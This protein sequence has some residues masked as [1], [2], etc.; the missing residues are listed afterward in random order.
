[1]WEAM[2]TASTKT[3]DFHEVGRTID[4]IMIELHIDN[5]ILTTYSKNYNKISDMCQLSVLPGCKI[6]RGT[7]GGSRLLKAQQRH[8]AAHDD[9][10]KRNRQ[11]PLHR[12]P[13][14]VAQWLRDTD[15]SDGHIK[16]MLANQNTRNI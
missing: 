10:C 6:Q 12:S 13:T 16:F 15:R 9:I 2:R 14:T 11:I 8:T 1:M 4:Y 7:F 3:A 5:K